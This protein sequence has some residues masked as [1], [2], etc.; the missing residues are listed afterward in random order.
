MSTDFPWVPSWVQHLEI[1]VLSVTTGDMC[2]R[3]SVS[4]LCVMPSASQRAL[5][6]VLQGLCVRIPQKTKAEP[7]KTCDKEHISAWC[8]THQ[9]PLRFADVSWQD[10]TRHLVLWMRLPPGSRFCWQHWDN[11]ALL[12]H[13]TVLEEYFT[14]IF[15]KFCQTYWSVLL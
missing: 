2:L 7:Q 13:S 11:F 14:F 3:L 4:V 6:R 5:R 9:Q 15:V 1:R 8:W 10:H 12:F